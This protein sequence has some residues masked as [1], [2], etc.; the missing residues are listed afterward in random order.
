MN[1][2]SLDIGAE[3][4]KAVLACL[5]IGV[6]TVDRLLRVSFV[7]PAAQ[8]MIERGDGLRLNGDR[9]YART[10]CETRLLTTALNSLPPRSAN[11]PPAANTAKASKVVTISRG[12]EGAMYRVVIAPLSTDE[13][14]AAQAA[15][16]AL[17][18]DIIH[19]P[20]AD[21][22][23]QFWQQEFL[24]TRAE[25]RL[26]VQLMAGASLTQ[27]ADLLGVTHNTVRSQ[28]RAIFEKTQA[29]R[30]ADLVRMLQSHRS[31]RRLLV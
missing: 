12:D 29:R 7:S 17:F 24:L 26:A 16:A 31:L 6:L 11:D 27:A 20:D 30:Q 23:A 19:E 28:L 10:A 21:E 22:E 8:R 25:A 18:I 9:L 13:T 3:E 5:E 2:T 4:L 15:E 14:P 1:R